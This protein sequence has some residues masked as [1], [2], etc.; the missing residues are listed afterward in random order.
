MPSKDGPQVCAI[1]EI[2]EFKC[3][4]G[5]GTFPFI[6]VIYIEDKWVPSN[7]KD[8]PPVALD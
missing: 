4:S 6:F 2:N 8:D 7:S 1:N 3:T 5:F